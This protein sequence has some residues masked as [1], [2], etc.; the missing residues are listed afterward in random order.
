M[1]I[2]KVSQTTPVP[3]QVINEYST[4][5]RDTYSCDY[6]NSLTEIKEI[7]LTT[8]FDFAWD[9]DNS[10]WKIGEIVNLNFTVI[11]Y[12]STFSTNTW[13][14]IAQLPS[15]CCPTSDKGLSAFGCTDDF[16][17]PTAVPITI[18]TDGSI[19]I[20]VSTALNKIIV[21]ASYKITDN[22]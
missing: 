20:F 11:N 5:T 3:T 1:R 13:V 17:S 21:S 4:S 10:S 8:S 6:V 12:E 2:K 9:V 19:K 7:S 22:T 14:K 15:N 16:A 18:S